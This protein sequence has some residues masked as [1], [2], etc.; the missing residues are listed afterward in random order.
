M[1]Q[2]LSSV[3]C[4]LSP[5]HHSMQL[6]QF[7]DAAAGGLVIE[8][9][10]NQVKFSHLRNTLLDRK[11]QFHFVIERHGGDKQTERHTD[12]ATYRLNHPRSLCCVMHNQ[13]YKVIELFVSPEKVSHMQIL[14]ETP[15]QD[16]K[17]TPRHKASEDLSSIKAGCILG[18]S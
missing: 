9:I 15:P 12:I 18:L 3:T 16:I 6:H 17:P 11:S 2:I 7:G 10:E 8:R 4:H 5:D 13:S 14:T 1:K